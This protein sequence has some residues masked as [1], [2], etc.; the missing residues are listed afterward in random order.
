MI[1]NKKILI[2]GGAGFI[3]HNL[4][5]A[6]KSLSA[7]V[8]IVDGLSINN[9]GSLKRNINK[10]PHPKLSIK[11]LKERIRLIKKNKIPLRKIDARN[12]HKLSKVFNEFKPN[13]VVHLAAVSHANRSNKDP[14]STFDH[15][16][17]T[18]EN[19]LDNSRNKVDHFIFLS[20]S[21]VYGN[22][23]KNIVKEDDACEPLGIYAALKYSAEKIIK[24]YNQVFDLPYTIIR[25]SALYGER[26]ISRRVGQIFIENCLNQKKINIEGDGK[27]KLDFTYIKDLIQGIIKIIKKKKSLN[28]IFNITYGNAQP[29]KKLIEILSKEFSNI[30]VQYTKRDKFMPKRGTLS[31]DKAK[32]MIGYRSNWPLHKGYREYIKWYKNLYYN[33]KS[34]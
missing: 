17:R 14:H 9:L 13:V 5:L 22:F 31:T 10:L 29:I 28:Q 23:K 15:S 11:I 7:K 2:I 16:L 12:Y 18:L 27:E 1:K 8:M 24:S 25:P 20:S 34:D 26:C 4:A 32:R 30:Q 3:G 33:R 6:L 19:S 21:M